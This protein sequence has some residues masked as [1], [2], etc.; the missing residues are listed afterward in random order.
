TP[1]F[2]QASAPSGTVNY[3][4]II[5]ADVPGGSTGDISITFSVPVLRVGGQVYAV[6]GSPHQA[7]ASLLDHPS[8]SLDV[9]ADG[10][11]IGCL[12]LASSQSFDWGGLDQDHIGLI[13]GSLRAAS[14]SRSYEAASDGQT[15]SVTRTSGT[16]SSPVGVFATWGPGGDEEPSPAEGSGASSAVVSSSGEGHRDASG[17]GEA[18]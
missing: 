14:A 17:I 18:S 15:L 11:A 4:G 7:D 10:F 9:P 13:G 5:S 1:V 12:S 8:V 3:A 6:T 2:Q 16:W